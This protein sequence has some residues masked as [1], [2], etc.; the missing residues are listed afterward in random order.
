M[1]DCS[2]PELQCLELC[3]PHP[4]LCVQHGYSLEE[5]ALAFRRCQRDRQTEGVKNPRRG[6]KQKEVLRFL[7]QDWRGSVR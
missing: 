3:S 2:V 1:V 6:D 4:Q 7:Q 5:V